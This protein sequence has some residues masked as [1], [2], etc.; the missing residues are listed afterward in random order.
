MSADGGLTLSAATY[1]SAG[2]LYVTKNADEDKHVSYTFTDKDGR[3][4]LTRKMASGVGHDTYS[5]YDDLGNL[6]YVLQPMYQDNSSLSL[7][8]FQYKYDD[9]GRCI[10]KKMPGSD[11]VENVYDD[12]YQLEYSIVNDAG[13]RGFPEHVRTGR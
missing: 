1:Y 5:V 12:A 7:Y 9:R 8:A 4:L 3:I 2:E 10:W 13:N 11:Y 6:C